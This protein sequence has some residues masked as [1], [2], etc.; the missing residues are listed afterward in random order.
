MNTIIYCKNEKI[1]DK[2]QQ[3]AVKPFLKEISSIR[4]KVLK[5]VVRLTLFLSL[6][7]TCLRIWTE[8]DNKCYNLYQ[9]REDTH[10]KSVFLVV[11]PL[12]V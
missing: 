8:L 10:K 6:Y 7:S 11:G 9:L 5:G 3:V 12:R 1:H 2:K 4:L